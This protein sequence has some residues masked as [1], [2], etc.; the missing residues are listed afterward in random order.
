MVKTP[1]NILVMYG[2]IGLAIAGGVVTVSEVTST[3]VPI[4]PKSG[5]LGID[6]VLTPTT[7]VQ[8]TVPYNTYSS[9]NAY[10]SDG[11]YTLRLST[12]SIMVYRTGRFSITSGWTTIPVKT[13]TV[14]LQAGTRVHLGG[15]TLPESN[16]TMIRVNLIDVT[17]QRTSQG[18]WESVRLPSGDIPARAQVKA[19][20]T[21]EVLVNLHVECPT[22]NSNG[23]SS[24]QVGECTL[25]PSAEDED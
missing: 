21:I 3:V 18:V 23:H 7:T 10:G 15:V 24:A 17:I 4:F 9:L 11:Q 2:L 12:D 16:V 13:K 25:N 14:T 22:G 6:L 20:A 8:S 5:Q 1:I 19:H